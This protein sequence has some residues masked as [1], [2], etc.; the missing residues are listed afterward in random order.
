MTLTDQ[1]VDL[2]VFKPKMGSEIDTLIEH[3]LKTTYGAGDN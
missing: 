1:Y 3:D 2:N